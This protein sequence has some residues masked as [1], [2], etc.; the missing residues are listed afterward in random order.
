MATDSPARVLGLKTKGRLEIGYDA[1][2][3]V[4]DECF[5]VVET[6]VM[7]RTVYRVGD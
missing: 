2:I 4:M 1:D 6:I 7:G 3:V 5:N